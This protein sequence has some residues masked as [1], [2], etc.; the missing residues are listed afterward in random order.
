MVAG[1]LSWILQIVLKTAVVVGLW[2]TVKVIIRN[3]GGTLKD[4]LETL[5]LAIRYGCLN[6]KAKLVDK[7]IRE[8]AEE[9]KETEE[10]NG[11]GVKA[12]GTVV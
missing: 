6:L 10:Q 8:N 9:K 7:L 3:G 12:E 1:I 11:Q 4:I 2:V 5:V